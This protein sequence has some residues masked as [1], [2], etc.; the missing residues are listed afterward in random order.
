MNSKTLTSIVLTLLAAALFELNARADIT[1][2]LV[3]YWNLSDG[4]GSS[5]VVDFSG[6]GN[7]GTLVNYA[8]TTYS[9]MWTTVTDP[10]NGWPFALTFT[11]SLAGF[12]TNTYINVAD[13]PSLNLPSANKTWTLSAWVNCSVAGASE[14]ANAGIIS[15]GNLNSEA[16]ALYMSAGKF[17]TI[18]HNTSLGS[19]ET[20]TSTTVATA[21]TWYHVV[22]V[23]QEPLSGSNAE[24]RLYINGT[25][26]SGANANTFTTVYTTNSPV[27]IGC[28]ANASGTINL[29]FQGTIDEVR[30]YDRALTSADV[31]QLYQNRAF[32]L[33]DSNISY[34]N[35][36]GGSGGNA[37]L[38]TTSLNFCTNL[39][40]ASLGAAASLGTVLGVETANSLPPGCVF[41][42]TYYNNRRAVVVPSTNLTI[43]AGGVAL[44]TASG[45]G[46][47]TF[48]NAAL[49]YTHNTRDNFGLNA[50]PNPT[51]LAQSGTGTVILTGTNT[52]TGGTT[53]N[54][55]AIQLGNGGPVSGQELGSTTAVVDN[56]TLVFNG[57]N[58]PSFN[59]TISGTGAVTQKGSG[60]V[61]L[62]GASTY[63]GITALNSGTLSVNAVADSGGTSAIGYGNMTISGGT[64][65]YTGSSSATTARL[66]TATG[67]T[68]SGLDVPGSAGSL[69][70]TGQ[71]KSTAIFTVNKTGTGTLIL[72]GGADNA[73]LGMNINVGTVILNKS[74]VPGSVRA[75]GE[76]TTVGSGATLQLSGSGGAEINNNVPLTINS[77]GLFDLNSQSD[78]ISSLTLS[79]TGISSGGALINSAAT[80]SSTLTCPVTLAASSSIGG[81]GN[82]TLPGIISGFSMSLTYA[83]TGTLTLQ[84]ANT[85]TGGTIINSGLLDIN[86]GLITGNITLNGSGTLELDNNG[87]IS[88]I[89]TL[90]LPASPAASSVNLNFSGTQN[91]GLLV[92]GATSM[93]AGTYGA[94]GS[95]AVN[96]NAAFTGPGILDVTGVAYWDPGSLGAAPGSG[97]NGNWD[98]STS[99]WTTGGADTTWPADALAIFAGTPGTVTLAANENADELTFSSAGYIVTNTDGVS[100]LTLDGSSPTIIVPA[101]NTAI[102]AT[103]AESG[104]GAV[105]VSGPGTLTLTGANSYS[106]G[107]T[108][109]G[110]T[111][112]ANTIADANSS[113]GPAGPVTFLGGGALSYT[114]SS[115]AVTSRAF[116]AGASNTVN[117]IDVPAGSLEIDGA[118]TCAGS[119]T[120]R[121]TSPGTLILGG[122][123][124]NPSLGLAITQGEVIIT[125]ASA[126][127]VH[128][129]G[130]NTTTVGTGAGGNS[131]EL[132]LSGSGGFD[133]FNTCIITVNSPD[134]FVDLNGQND[135]F[136]TL[137]LSGAGPG[138][139]GA[140]INNSTASAITNGGSGVVLAGNTT[141]GGSG[142]ITLASKISGSGMSLTYAGTATLALTNASTYSGGTI[143]N[144][145]ATVLLTN[146]AAAAGTGAI[147]VNG[148]LGV[149]IVGNNV[150]L[151]NAISGP[152]I[153]NMI[154]TSGNNLQLGGSMSGFTGTINCPA[155]A[156]TAKVQIL[157]TG[158]GLTSAATI[159]VAAG[160]TFYVANPGVI[161]PA[162]VNLGGL[163]NSE[164][165]GALRLENGSTVS[166]PVT[167]LANTTM[168]NGQSGT[169]K[170]ATISGPI[171][172][173]NGTFG[174]TFTAEPGTLVLS[175]TNT[176]GGATTIS[177]GVL[178]IGGAGE[179]GGGNYATN[180]TDNAVFDYASSASQTLSGV[181]SGTGLLIQAGPGPLT[182][183][184]TNTYTGGTVISNNSTLTIG[185]S[186]SLGAAGASNS[187]A[188]NIT[189]NGTFQY[190]SSAA[191]TLAGVVSGIGALTQNGPGTLTLSG[192]DSYSGATT[193]S[194]AA[195]LVLA[196]SGSINNT[197][198][199]NLTAGASFDVSAF[200]LSYTFGGGTILKAAGTGTTAGSSAAEIIG[201]ASGTIN[202][203][204]TLALTFTPQT[205]SGDTNH[206]ALFVPQG[207]LN[208]SGNGI[209]VSNAAAT[210][211]GAGTYTLIQ[212]AAG[213]LNATG[214]NITVTG[215]G[216]A[217]GT[218]ASLSVSGGSMN[219]V[220]VTTFVPAPAINSVVL[221]GTSLIFSGT[222]GAHGGNF[223]VLTSTDITL[224]LTN[225]TSI[226]TN[227][228]SATGTFSVTNPVDTGS[229]FFAIKIP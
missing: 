105:T 203:G 6:N 15:K 229:R 35:G 57:N 24:A 54:S 9:N 136:S 86:A 175:G 168:G 73:F 142:N 160:G 69:E 21:G 140:L 47:V 223:E 90:T 13:S 82:I 64:L 124:D 38:D 30:I 126:S 98:S 153:V 129:L 164:V 28:R 155:S 100:V 204:G 80:T 210:P 3:G 74:S 89:A 145:N 78:T 50:G 115:P 71:I 67:G 70:F 181:V 147:S 36:L 154:E 188:A 114:G 25:L 170:L 40:T 128:G 109:I 96:Q 189:N 217:P 197:A 144:T 193:V 65:S 112:N 138:G 94:P 44:G 207:S 162:R 2:G 22:G 42:D 218:A 148:T 182:L 18:F 156:T 61:T 33:V 119:A 167:L 139:N 58:N 34:W 125:K 146:A 150:I 201:G 75:L 63:T 149:G 132:Q 222:N 102:G 157:T 106:G 174:I 56:G 12:G 60:S 227:S 226:A 225:W 49:T 214:T 202:V 200:G 62:S 143:V 209:T 117:V 31:L 84:G 211:L 93:P 79:G 185:G 187:Y 97:G 194:P 29:P 16:Y 192:T 159:N 87:S 165:Y 52:F 179:L 158:V 55:G 133:L 205:F 220:V 107:T 81:S 20:A 172:Q 184:T 27:T 17:V 77:G 46:T 180:L 59:I 216:L 221:S 130:G 5:N 176:Y 43:A 88:S 48:A 111:V 92:I 224:P 26:Q 103:I 135:S 213:T 19:A 8:D 141:I 206:P 10:T 195:T 37:T 151:A 113:I 212:V 11:N 41:A 76:P 169:A 68:T 123:V 173:S 219:L 45:A 7:T 85:Y 198:S 53:I 108:I 83:G 116:S 134:G 161:I 104:S 39:Y 152:G 196:G 199:V 91:I 137:T 121:K 95:G 110:A 4:P 215:A 122:S 183:T 163:G 186:G 171:S 228:F 1:T 178:A 66:V 23:V 177:G 51:S 191:Q 118:I 101:G 32:S 166:G 190:S 120:I 14:T 131:A 72:S 127:N 208:L 99:D